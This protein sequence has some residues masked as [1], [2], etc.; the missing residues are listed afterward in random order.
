MWIHLLREIGDEYGCEIVPYWGY[1]RSGVWPKGEYGEG[2]YGRDI[3]V[4]TNSVSLTHTD[5]G[6]G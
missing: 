3:S 2:E 5:N 4:Q 1:A 6:L